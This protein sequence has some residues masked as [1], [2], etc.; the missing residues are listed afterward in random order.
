[1]FHQRS[2]HFGVAKERGK[3]EGREFVVANNVRVSAL[4]QQQAHYPRVTMLR[5]AH[6][7]RHAMLV[8]RIK[9]SDA[10]QKELDF[11]KLA[12]FRRAPQCQRYLVGLV[13]C[14]FDRRHL[15]NPQS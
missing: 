10:R 14:V 15:L 8:T 13:S 1:M 12:S 4:R 6:Q 7:C 3:R 5:R 11:M 9:V 2:D